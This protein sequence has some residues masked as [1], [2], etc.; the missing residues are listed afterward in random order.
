MHGLWCPEHTTPPSPSRDALK[1]PSDTVPNTMSELLLADVG[2]RIVLDRFPIGDLI[3]PWER[4][5][6]T[7]L[8]G[9]LEGLRRGL[10]D[11]LHRGRTEEIQHMHG[12][13]DDAIARLEEPVPGVQQTIVGGDDHASAVG[14]GQCLPVKEKEMH[15]ED[16]LD[17]VALHVP[18]GPLAP[19]H[20]LAAASCMDT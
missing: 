3:M 4:R 20:R 16:A 19:P 11:Q 7:P 5:L 17:C 8:T 6:P 9:F 10:I 18:V 1:M 15:L 12:P 2:L 13:G 14:V